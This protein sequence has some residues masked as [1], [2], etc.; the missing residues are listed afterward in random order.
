MNQ[1]DQTMIAGLQREVELL[2]ARLVSLQAQITLLEFCN[3]SLAGGTG[4]IPVKEL[5]ATIELLTHLDRAGGLGIDVHQLIRDE[6]ARL[7]SLKAKGSH[8]S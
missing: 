5:D 2:Q 4:Y 3:S 7:Q 8:E 6:I 1:E